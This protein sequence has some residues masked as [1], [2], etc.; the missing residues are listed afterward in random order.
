MGYIDLSGKRFGR[1]I[2]G[3]RMT[4]PTGKS[5]WICECDCG[6]SKAVLG[7]SLRN[8]KTKSCGCFRKESTRASFSVHG[9]CKSAEYQ[10]WQGMH[11]RCS[12]INNQ[13]YW[14][15]GGRGIKVCS[16]WSSFANF[17]A[18]MGDKPSV[19]M[20]I[21]RIDNDLGYS[22]ENCRWATDSEQSRNKHNTLIV[23]Y[24]GTSIP[25]AD[26]A[27]YLKVNYHTFYDRLNK[28]KEKYDNGK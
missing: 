1:L 22:P 19:D 9:K 13:A 11:S 21:D 12:N 28:A 25:V 14:R 23:T 15:Y 5:Y 6:N 20:S 17:Y 26:L 3:E 16:R 8:G 24:K 10:S 27:D 7:E 4:S 2:A 18:D